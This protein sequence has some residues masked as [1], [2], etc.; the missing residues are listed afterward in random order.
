MIGY[1]AFRQSCVERQCSLRMRA[2]VGG[3]GRPLVAV[4]PCCGFLS[5]RN[6]R[7]HL[8]L[9][10]VSCKQSFIYVLCSLALRSNFQKAFGQGTPK[11]SNPNALFELPQQQ[12]S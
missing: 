10:L 1:F 3:F 6:V 8:L 2:H 4:V 12:S 7:A 11:G 5:F 9:V